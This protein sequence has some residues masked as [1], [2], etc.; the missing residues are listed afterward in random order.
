MN[1]NKYMDKLEDFLGLSEKKRKKKQDHLLKIINKLEDK[2]SSVK[3]KLKQESRKNKKSGTTNKLCKEFK[4][5]TKL[6]KTAKK[7]YRKV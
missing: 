4:V 3:K 1:L 6:L 5:L 2:K 7:H